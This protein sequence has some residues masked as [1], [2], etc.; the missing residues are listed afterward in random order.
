MTEEEIDRLVFNALSANPDFHAWL[1]NNYLMTARKTTDPH[2]ALV[3][4]AEAALVS[5][6]N[7]RYTRHMSNDGTK[8]D[9]KRRS[10]RI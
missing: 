7:A 4:N 2:Q 6:L 1:V 8:P 9:R 3:N 10:S 5:G